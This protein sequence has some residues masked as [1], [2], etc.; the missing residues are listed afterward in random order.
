MVTHSCVGNINFADTANIRLV[1]GIL[2]K[3]VRNEATYISNIYEI[4]I[5][6]MQF[7]WA[8]SFQPWKKI[9]QTL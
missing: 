1:H 2:M 4:Q 5:K 9:S 3:E 6:P 7:K 8:N